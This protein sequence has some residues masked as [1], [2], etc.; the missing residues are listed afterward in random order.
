MAWDF[1]ADQDFQ[2]TL[3]WITSFIAE[4]VQPLEPLL[5]Q[6]SVPEAA[7]L[8]EPLK[9]QVRDRGLWAVHLPKEL[10]GNGFGQLPLAQMNLI[11]GRVGVAMEVFG[12]M[13]PD[14]GN[15]ELIA[16]GGPS[17]K[18]SDGCGPT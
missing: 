18:K 9:Q 1:C 13:A 11:T 3:D 5:P 4:E 16:E 15:A 2:P 10:G 8:L 6:L 7:R 12:N 17:S 14:S